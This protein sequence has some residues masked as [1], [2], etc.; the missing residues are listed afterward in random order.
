M[1][2]KGKI[3]QWDD[4]RGFGFITPLGGGERAFFH[5]S[6]WPGG[7]RPVLGQV[8]SFEPEQDARGR[9][10]TMK[11]RRTGSD[12]VAV[13]ALAIAIGSL[14]LVGYGAARHFFL[15]GFSCFISA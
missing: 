9:R 13:Q 11:I 8:V 5:I 7:K 12:G 2:A 6:A 10:R 14:G 1:Q 3:S 15:L 4:E